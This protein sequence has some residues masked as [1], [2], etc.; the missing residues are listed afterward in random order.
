MGATLDAL[1][2]LQSIEL[3]LIELRR[4]I[5]AKHR[6]VQGAKKRLQHI[7]ENIAAKRAQRQR[8]QGDVDRIELDRRAR[9]EEIA[10]LREALNRAKTNKEYSAVLTQINTDKADNAKLEDRVLAMFA[11]LDQLKASVQELEE[12]RAKE[13]DRLVSLTTAASEFEASVKDDMV[14]LEQR[15]EEAAHALPPSALRTFERAAERHDG[16]AMAKIAQVDPRREEYVCEG[17]NM[18]VTLEVVSA[19]RGRDDIQVCNTCGRILHE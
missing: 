3:E 14:A 11:A 4:K 17:C 6:A 1:H 10:R 16:E 15:R 19:L 13:S 12:E 2:R 5:R 7:D 8:E 9:E 18:T